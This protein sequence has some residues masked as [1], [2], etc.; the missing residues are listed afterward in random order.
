MGELGV[1]PGPI[2]DLPHG[3]LPFAVTGAAGSQSK[4]AWV[5]R[6]DGFFRAEPVPLGPAS[7]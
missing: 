4:D 5:T 2:P 7:R 1:M 6:R 3:A